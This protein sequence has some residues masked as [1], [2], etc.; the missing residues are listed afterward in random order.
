MAINELRAI[1]EQY[2]QLEVFLHPTMEY[3]SKLNSEQVNEYFKK[4]AKSKNIEEHNYGKVKELIDAL[5]IEEVIKRLGC[6]SLSWS[7]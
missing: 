5:S 7:W 1:N 3:L 6:K 2:I 4:I